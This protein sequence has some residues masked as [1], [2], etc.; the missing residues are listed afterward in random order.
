[1]TLLFLVM[2][3]AFGLVEP[4]I[5]TVLAE[6]ANTKKFDTNYKIDPLKSDKPQDITPLTQSGNPNTDLHVKSDRTHDREDVSKR[7]AFTSTYIN[8]DGTKTLEYSPLQQNYNDGKTWQKIDNKLS[9]NGKAAQ[10]PNFFQSITNTAPQ[11]VKPTEFT[12]RS[13]VIGAQMDSLS[14]GITFTANGKKNHYDSTG[15]KGYCA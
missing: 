12:G 10:A 7:T 4:G 6:S 15:R 8:K 2:T 9:D 5:S 14:H 3:L 11:A 1:M 13:G